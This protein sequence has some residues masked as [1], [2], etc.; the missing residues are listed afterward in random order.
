MDSSTNTILVSVNLEIDVEALE[1]VV[2]NAK[3]LDRQG[4]GGAKM[5]TADTL[6]LMISRFLLKEDFTRFVKDLESYS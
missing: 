4:A 3:K 2:A 6:G 1:A 5:D